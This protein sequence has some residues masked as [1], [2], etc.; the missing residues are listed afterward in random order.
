VFRTRLFAAIDELQPPVN[1]RR[2]PE[3]LNVS[4]HNRCTGGR[5]NIV[6][7]LADNYSHLVVLMLVRV[8]LQCDG[9]GHASGKTMTACCTEGEGC[10]T[11]PL[12][13]QRARRV[14]VAAGAAQRHEFGHA[15]NGLRDEYIE[16]RSSSA[17]LT[18]PLPAEQSVFL[19]SNLS[20]S[21]SPCDMPWAHLAPGSEYN[22]NPF[23]PIG[24]LVRGGIQD[25]GVWHSE[26]KCLMNGTHKN[27]FCNIDEPGPDEPGYVETALRDERR[28]CFWCEEIVTIQILEKTRQFG[29]GDPSNELGRAW[30]TLWD[31]TLRDVYYQRFGIPHRIAQRNACLGFGECPCP[32]GDCVTSS[33]DPN[34]P[35]QNDNWWACNLDNIPACLPECTIREIGSAMYVDSAAGAPGNPGSKF[36]PLDDISGA[37]QNACG[38]SR[39][40]AIEPGPYPG[41]LTISTP[42]VL[43]PSACDPI[44]LGH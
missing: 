44:V 39:L 27:Y 23:S 43:I 2:Y 7:S 36:A 18:N 37:A 20:Y 26:Y 11:H 40:V 22:P 5:S 3:D 9:N 30:F 1:Y 42:A 13:S 32:F 19:L 15:F 29:P 17:C 12:E 6:P 16:P 21:N 14:R 31:T 8:G 28:F 4:V 10:G 25:V 33:C 34:N 41:P 24:N 35:S 38:P